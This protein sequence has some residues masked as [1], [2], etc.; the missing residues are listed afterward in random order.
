MFRFAVKPQTKLSILQDGVKL[1]AATL[2]K[3]WYLA[4]IL[5][6]FSAI[7]EVFQA[8]K[9]NGGIPPVFTLSQGI[10]FFIMMFISAFFIG[11]IMHRMYVLAT[12]PKI[13]LKTSFILAK[14]K[15]L[16]VYGAML[17]AALIVI[18]GVVAFVVPGIF[19]SVL[20]SFYLP[21]I[22][23]DNATVIDAIKRSYHLVWGWWWRTFF[24]MVVPYFTILVFIIA[25]VLMV[26][27]DNYLGQALSKIVVMTMLTPFLIAVILVLYNDMKLRRGINK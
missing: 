2:N 17:I 12:Q 23:L 21:L 26:G 9:G 22:L 27:Q 10:Y 11:V 24:V 19:L 15:W 16:T 1:Y 3:V 13:S 18:A 7:P 5:T 20:L 14:E 6:I 25:A 8:L 4:L